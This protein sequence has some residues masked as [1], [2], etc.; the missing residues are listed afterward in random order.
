MTCETFRDAVFDYLDG[1]L[2][3]R[4]G[5][6][7]H[8]DSCE[9]CRKLLGSIADQENLLRAARVPEAPADL[10]PR[11]AAQISLGRTAPFRGIRWAA[12]AAAA[13]ALILVG[14][15]LHSGRAEDRGLDVVVREISPDART[16][17]A[18]LV[19]RYEDVD[20]A[21][22]MVDTLFR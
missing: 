22:A 5:F 2:Q 17:F 21:S 12:G 14:A 11:I 20:T 18:T 8:L 13:A 15:L 19:P 10:W 4:A 9:P 7:G 1:T 3:D 6:R 16:A